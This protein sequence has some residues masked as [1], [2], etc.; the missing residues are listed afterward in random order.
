MPHD[1]ISTT[2]RAWREASFDD[3]SFDGERALGPAA[4]H[5]HGDACADC[6]SWWERQCRLARALRSVARL[7]V[8]QEL[9]L[10]TRPAELSEACTRAVLSHLSVLHAP[11]V[12]DRLVREEI[13]GQPGTTVRRFANDLERRAAPAALD[14]R[15][16]QVGRDAAA[17]GDEHGGEYYAESDV[18]S[19]AEREPSRARAFATPARAARRKRAWWFAASG[20][21]AA[22]LL[23]VWSYSVL[24]S[25]PRYR[26]EVVEIDAAQLRAQ[27]PLGFGFANGVTGGALLARATPAN[28]PAAGEGRR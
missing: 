2:C 15:V 6:R 27:S 19:D 12:L 11:S 18:E 10:R 14:A 22:G 20:A 21:L 8:P 5:G 17:R 23:G 7:D 1:P 4:V 16:Q 3:A 9:D 25:A 13:E 24:T 28:G 26:F